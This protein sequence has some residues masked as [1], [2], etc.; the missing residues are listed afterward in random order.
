[1]KN[2]RI[3]FDILKKSWMAFAHAVGWFNTRLLLTIFY[4]V[5][6]GI[7][8]IVLKLLGKD[9]LRRKPGQTMSYWVEKEK[10][11]NTLEEAKHQFRR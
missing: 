5:V 10:T 3:V 8:T 7:P 2:V 6:I 1:M 11:G 4:V 9:L